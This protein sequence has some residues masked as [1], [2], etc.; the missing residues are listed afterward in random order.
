M[1]SKTTL[2][3]KKNI[4]TVSHGKIFIQSSFN[5]TIISITD[6]SGNILAW[7]TSGHSGFKGARK[8]TP[9]AAQATMRTALE[10]AQSY[11]IQSVDILISGV[12]S[13]REAAVRALKGTDL[14]VMSIRDIT[15]IPHN[16]C[17]PKK[18]R[19]V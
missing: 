13:G 5:N 16:G 19:R 6:A 9:Y 7:S 17:R 4:R 2:K 3:K 15:P 18:P 12:G 1:L 11:N 10:K 8:A 14:I